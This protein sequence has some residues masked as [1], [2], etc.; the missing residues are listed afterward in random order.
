M[1]KIKKAYL[2]KMLSIDVGWYDKSQEQFVS[3]MSH[4][5]Q[6]M[7]VLFDSKMTNA[8]EMFS[9]FFFGCVAGFMASWKI[10]FLNLGMMLVAMIVMY[11]ILQIIKKKGESRHQYNIKCTKIASE[12]LM[13]THTVAAYGGECR[14]SERYKNT[15]KMAN[16]YGLKHAAVISVGKALNYFQLCLCYLVAYY[17]S[18]RLYLLSD[19]EPSYIAVILTA[20]INAI[21]HS[22]YLLSAISD[23]YMATDSAYRIIRFLDK[24]SSYSKSIEQGIEPDIFKADISF[25]NVNF[26]YPTNLQTKVLHGLTLDIVF[27]KV[28]A[29]VGTSGA[30]KSTIVNLITRL[31]DVTAGQILIGGVDIRKLNVSWLR[32][33]IGVVGQEPTLFDT[34]VEEN[35]KYGEINATLDEIIKAAKISYAH[36]FIEQLPLGYGSIV[37]QS[38]TKLS[39]GQKQRIAIARAIVKNPKLLLLDEATS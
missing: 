31:H 32:N 21:Y 3:T 34:S 7:M 10:A 8:V 15:L 9:I 28:T 29:V 39:G 12:V 27:G 5:L 13:N 1:I 23:L 22:I 35:I 4:D 16:T 36:E 37:G 14:E 38:G 33:Q 17:F 20:Q 26:S 19:F 18:A 30:G 2:S 11:F 25:K 24:E 6:K